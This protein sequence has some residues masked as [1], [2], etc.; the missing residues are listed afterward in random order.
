MPQLSLQVKRQ[1]EGGKAGQVARYVLGFGVMLFV[2]GR[3]AGP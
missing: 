2:G 3:W 1:V